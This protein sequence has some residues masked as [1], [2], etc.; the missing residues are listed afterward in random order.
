M[1]LWG[2]KG[3][4]MSKK[5]GDK[6]DK[7][8]KK[9]DESRRGAKKEGSS[10]SSGTSRSRSGNKKHD[11]HHKPLAL[12]G[13]SEKASSSV[14]ESRNTDAPSR[15]NAEFH[16]PR[17][18]GSE[19]LRR[20]VSGQR[21]GQGGG[22]ERDSFYSAD[23]LRPGSVRSVASSSSERR[24]DEI[25]RGKMIQESTAIPLGWSNMLEA[26]TLTLTM[27]RHSNESRKQNEK[28]I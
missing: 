20:H 6:K 26:H 13:N 19:D 16:P 21:R 24:R 10:S 23:S 5:D 22:A 8:D 7:K 17:I 3:S 2:G 1:P 12:L 18:S 15:S 25:R 28:Q 4:S 14:E 27:P 9:V 11:K